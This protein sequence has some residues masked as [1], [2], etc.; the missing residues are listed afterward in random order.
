LFWGILGA[1]FMRGAMIAVG[2]ALISR[3]GWM[4]YVFGGL[5]IVTAVKLLVI[6]HDNIEPGRNPFV[7]LL[8][9]AYPITDRID[10]NRFFTYI[11]ARRAITPLFI[12]LVLV[13]SS[14]VIFALDSV[15][16]VFAVTLD[17]FIVFTSNIFAVLGMRA[18]YFVLAGIMDRFRYLK[19]S[20]VFVLAFVGA[21]MLLA[22]HHPIPTG[23]SL[24]V[25]AGIMA[26]GVLASIFAAGRDTAPL[27]SPLAADGEIRRPDSA[28]RD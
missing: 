12:A 6:R 9:R 19:M 2:S 11:N 24:S 3:F 13:E 5:L 25:I 23:V 1:L 4:V 21:K 20:L 27:V 7:R 22:H 28:T 17:P 10:S 15:P 14:D 26:V 18:L 16:A 8:R